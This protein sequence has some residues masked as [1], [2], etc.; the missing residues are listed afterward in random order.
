M[1]GY[2]VSSHIALRAASVHD[3]V[4]RPAG[5]PGGTGEV[6]AWRFDGKGSM[7]EPI[8]TYVH[9]YYEDIEDLYRENIYR[10]GV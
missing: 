7:K 5:R 6:H 4:A 2:I 10:L 3:V 9:T 8:H 1:N